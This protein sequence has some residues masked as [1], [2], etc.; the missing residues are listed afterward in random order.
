V[1][2]AGRGK[3]PLPEAREKRA[4][5]IPS[6][7]CP[8]S[9]RILTAGRVEMWRG[10]RRYG[11]SVAAS[12]VWRSPS[13]RTITPFPHPAHRAGIA[14]R[15]HPALGQNITPSPT[16]GRAQVAPD[17]RARSARTRHIAPA[18]FETH[19]RRLPQKAW[20]MR[21]R[22]QKRQENAC[23]HGVRPVIAGAA[24]VRHRKRPFRILTRRRRSASLRGRYAATKDRESL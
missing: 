1:C 18:S 5:E 4:R 21:L 11:L 12:F 19:N 16:T 15:P 14:D 24:S 22:E 10:D 7:G 23:P 17:A 2:E 20:H 6:S 3:L 13:T 9:S 8:Q